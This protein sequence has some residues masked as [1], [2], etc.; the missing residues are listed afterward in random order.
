MADG[1]VEQVRDAVIGLRPV[2]T[3]Q[4]NATELWLAS[5]EI[6]VDRRGVKSVVTALARSYALDLKA[7]RQQLGQL[8]ERSM[9]L[10]FYLGRRVFV[11]LKM[12]K[13]LM[14][15]DMVY[16]YFD[17]DYIKDIQG[18]RFRECRVLLKTCDE[19]KALS[20]QATAQKSLH[21]GLRLLEALKGDTDD[22]RDEQ[23]VMESVGA[24]YRSLKEILKRLQSIEA[25]IAEAESSY[26]HDTESD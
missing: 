26:H 12:R 8:L 5:G 9:I 3:D 6:L 25:H 13:A 14:D 4:G 22:T 15:N 23:Q 7:Q 11:P 24:L 10:P 18:G 19:F 21:L 1:R 2:Y 17:A 20:S 16:G